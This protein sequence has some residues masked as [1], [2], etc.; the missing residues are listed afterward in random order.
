[1]TDLPKAPKK[2][3]PNSTY[4]KIDNEDPNLV[5]SRTYYDSCG[6]PIERIDY[7]RGSK[8]HRHFIEKFVGKAENHKHIFKYNET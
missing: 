2:S 7:F 4:E 1:M 8:L 3:D 5:V 6:R